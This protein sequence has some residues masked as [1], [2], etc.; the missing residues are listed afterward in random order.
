MS[1]SPADHHPASRS[2]VSSLNGIN[3]THCI[4]VPNIYTY[5]DTQAHVY[6]INHLFTTCNNVNKCKINFISTIDN[7]MNFSDH[8]PFHTSIA[9]ELSILCNFLEESSRNY[10]N[11][12]TT[13][14][15]TLNCMGES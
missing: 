1:C 15:N 7:Y 11:K 10:V 8:F 13:S 6:C 12:L 5:G 14:V 4:P 9:G 2:L 3:A